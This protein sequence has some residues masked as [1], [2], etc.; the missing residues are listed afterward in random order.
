LKE[1]EITSGH[2][3]SAVIRE[4]RIRRGWTQAALGQLAGDGTAS[5]NL[6]AGWVSVIENRGRELKIS[7]AMPFLIVLD[8]TLVARTD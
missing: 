7:T 1:T 5:G 3:L 6:A 2:D 4:E 8:I